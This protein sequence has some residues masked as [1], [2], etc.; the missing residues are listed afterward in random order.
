MASKPAAASLSRYSRSSSAPATQPI[1]SST[2][3]RISAGTSPRTTTSDTARRPPGFSTRKA[4]DKGASLGA[5]SFAP[6]V[7]NTAPRGAGGGGSPPPP[8]LGHFVV[9]PPAPP[10]FP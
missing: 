6:P 9:G 4:S 8:P 7:G 2:L 1:Q 5:R 3:R 10:F